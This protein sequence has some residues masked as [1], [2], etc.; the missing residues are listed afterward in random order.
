MPRS[1]NTPRPHVSGP[2]PQPGASTLMRAAIVSGLSA[3]GFGALI[4]LALAG[5]R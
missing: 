1:R 4:V 3:L 5:V 2:L